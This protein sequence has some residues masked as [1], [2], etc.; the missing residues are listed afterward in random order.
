MVPLKQ[1][2][3]Q[4]R[5]IP[6][7][8]EQYSSNLAPEM[9]ITKETEYIHTFIVTP[10]LGFSVTMCTTLIQPKNIYINTK[11]NNYNVVNVQIRAIKDVSVT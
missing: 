5:I 2:N 11:K 4:S 3:T 8:L 9:Y 6:E 1:Y 7:I 10:K